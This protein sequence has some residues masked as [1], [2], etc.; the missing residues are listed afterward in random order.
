MASEEGTEAAAYDAQLVFLESNGAFNL[1]ILDI[2]R[3]RNRVLAEKRKMLQT[4]RH[5][6]RRADLQKRCGLFAQMTSRSILGQAP[7]QPRACSLPFRRHGPS[8]ANSWRL[9]VALFP[10]S[11]Q[12]SD[13]DRLI[14]SNLSLL[15]CLIP[16]R[17]PLLSPLDRTQLDVAFRP[18]VLAVG[19]DRSWL[20]REKWE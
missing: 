10:G 12:S 1:Q 2:R 15:R 7:F 20:K 16:Y 3:S 4:G 19:R 17:P 13:V 8:G 11:Q 5:G 6:C 14:A 18:P 9:L